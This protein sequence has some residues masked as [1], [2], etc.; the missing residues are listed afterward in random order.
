MDTLVDFASSSCSLRAVI[1]STGGGGEG[2]RLDTVVA[3]GISSKILNP[4]DAVE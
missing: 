4:A 3:V 1:G 2:V